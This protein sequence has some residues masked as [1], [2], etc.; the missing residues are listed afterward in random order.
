MLITACVNSLICVNFLN[1]IFC[2]YNYYIL[3]EKDELL[4]ARRRKL[5]PLTSYDAQKRLDHC[6]ER[7]EPR[8]TSFLSCTVP[9]ITRQLIF[10]SAETLHN[11]LRP[12]FGSEF[13]LIERHFIFIMHRAHYSAAAIHFYRAPGITPQP[14]IFGGA[15]ILHNALRPLLDSGLFSMAQQFSFIMQRVHYSAVGYLLWRNFL[16]YPSPLY[17]IM[18]SAVIFYFN[19]EF[20]QKKKYESLQQLLCPS[21]GIIH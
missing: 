20:L 13:F 10:C 21:T 3:Q 6:S 9:I 18:R 1:I 15:T 19:P 16:F 5:S 4:E 17:P 11:T 8:K 12:L 7:G 2:D 14:L